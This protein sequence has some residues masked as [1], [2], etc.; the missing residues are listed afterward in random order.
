M[1]MKTTN[2]DISEYVDELREAT[3]DTLITFSDVFK[4]DLYKDYKAHYYRIIK[5]LGEEHPILKSPEGA[6][7]FY[8]EEQ[9]FDDAEIWRH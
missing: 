2:I 9:G 3:I 1:I 6:V 4:H 7:D 8:L 5:E